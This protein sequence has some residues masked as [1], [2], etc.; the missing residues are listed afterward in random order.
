MPE[1][2]VVG[3]Q[4]PSVISH[5]YRLLLSKQMA[6]KSYIT[7]PLYFVAMV[8]QFPLWPLFLR[9]NRNAS[10]GDSRW[11]ATNN[12]DCNK[13]GSWDTWCVISYWLVNICRRFG[14]ACRHATSISYEISEYTSTI[15]TQV[16][17]TNLPKRK[18]QIQPGQPTQHKTKPAR[19][20]S[21]K[22]M[23]RFIYCVK[24]RRYNPQ[25]F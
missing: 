5:V 21:M 7:S 25:T 20:Q 11:F 9:L 22:L 19:R 4:A 17:T 6:P 24:I 18:K 12:S 14:G 3:C 16:S 10:I 13:L 15:Q 2:W 1:S 8:T 23:L